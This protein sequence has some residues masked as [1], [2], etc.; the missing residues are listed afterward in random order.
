[1]T[2]MQLEVM[3]LGCVAVATLATGVSMVL[4]MRRVR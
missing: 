4:A 2:V 3:A 1:M